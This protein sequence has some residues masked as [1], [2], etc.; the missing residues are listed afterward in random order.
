M[1]PITSPYK[2]LYIVHKQHMHRKIKQTQYDISIGTICTEACLIQRKKLA[3][4]M[5]HEVDPPSSSAIASSCGKPPDDGP[6]CDDMH[7][8]IIKRFNS[9][10]ELNSFDSGATIWFDIFHG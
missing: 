3:S 7:V 4:A 2:T 5:L 8:E 10:I 1:Q 9:R 6:T